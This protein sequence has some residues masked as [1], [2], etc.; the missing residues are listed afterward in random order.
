MLSMLSSL[1]RVRLKSPKR[2]LMIEPEKQP[3]RKYHKPSTVNDA[4]A[5]TNLFFVCIYIDYNEQAAFFKEKGQEKEEDH[6]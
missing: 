2:K 5:T 4:I 3:R 6:Y 1:W